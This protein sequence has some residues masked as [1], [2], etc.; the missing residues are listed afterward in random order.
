MAY[1]FF[2]TKNLAETPPGTTTLGNSLKVG[3]YYSNFDILLGD[4]SFLAPQL[5]AKSNTLLLLLYISNR[6]YCFAVLLPFV[7]E[8]GWQASDEA[9]KVFSPRRRPSK[10]GLSSPFT[11][12]PAEDQI[13]TSISDSIHAYT[14]FCVRILLLYYFC[15]KYRALVLIE[16]ED[17]FFFFLFFQ[18]GNFVSFEFWRRFAQPILVRYEN[19]TRPNPSFLFEIEAFERRWRTDAR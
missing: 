7:P 9:K 15:L 18:W 8:N 3:G 6:P 2:L 5:P 10:Y 19:I 4:D 13:I 11:L 14:V 1:I 12:I 16:V 17:N